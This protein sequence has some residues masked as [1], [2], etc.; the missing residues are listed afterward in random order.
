MK[1]LRLFMVL[2]FAGGAL[3]FSFWQRASGPTSVCRTVAVR[4]AIC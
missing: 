4:E 1:Q 3:G 2:V